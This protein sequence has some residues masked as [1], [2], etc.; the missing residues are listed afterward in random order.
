MAKEHIGE[1]RITPRTVRIGHEVYPLANISRVQTLRLIWGG[2][3]ATL[4]PL[5]QIATLLLVAGV[6]FVAAS[7]VLPE[8]NLHPGF[9][10]EN[11]AQRFTM[12]AFVLA[13]IRLAYLL[14]VLLHRLLIR[15][16]RYALMIEASGTQYTALTGTDRDEIHRLKGK[17]VDAIED[18]PEQ[19]TV[20]HV[21]G[22]LVAGDK[23]SGG[24]Q[25]KQQGGRD[26]NMTFNR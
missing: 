17:I 16:T 5:R 12:G 3:Y 6:V 4:Y 26:S 20:I 7:I 22:D 2:K 24:I 21:H 9:D 18:P 8:L 13:A 1:I 15:R 23:V 19:E 11:A 14:V 10:V 25:Y